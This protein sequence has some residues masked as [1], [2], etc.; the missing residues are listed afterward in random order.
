MRRRPIQVKAYFNEKEYR[1]LCELSE[2]TKLAKGQLIRYLVQG[3]I[4]P[5]PPPVDYK[6]LIRELRMLGNNINQILVI[7]RSNGILNTV[8]LQ[9]HLTELEELMRK[10]G[11][12]YD[13][14]L[15]EKAFKCCV[16]AHKGQKRLSGEEYYMHPFYV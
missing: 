9:K 10:Q 3:Y 12:N 2:K 4:P 16:D 1:N 15:V 13:F 7:A 11:G 14:A 6:K 8:E 5:V